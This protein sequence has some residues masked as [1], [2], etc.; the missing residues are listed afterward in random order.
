MQQEHGLM[1]RPAP[2]VSDFLFD[3]FQ[4]SHLFGPLSPAAG[5]PSSSEAASPMFFRDPVWS[6]S[7][8]RISPMS[9]LL[10]EQAAD[11]RQGDE[12]PDPTSYTLFSPMDFV[13]AASTP[14]PTAAAPEL[15]NAPASPLTD[16][17]RS[18]ASEES[19]RPRR[20]RSSVD[21]DDGEGPK[22]T[23]LNVLERARREGLKSNF[24]RLR[25]VV[26]TLTG[27]KRVS[28]GQILRKA[29]DYIRELDSQSRSL[30][31]SLTALRCERE[32]LLE[33]RQAALDAC[34]L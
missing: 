30:E 33:S 28:K 17:T 21:S 14:L 25:D 32:R 6:E 12:Q 5:S 8:G 16:E 9:M 3:S 24:Y 26:P 19:E 10:S 4:A 15:G 1:L 22:R 29:V 23:V 20:R 34:F 31:L 13:T 18:P 7:A 2:I 27:G 11:A